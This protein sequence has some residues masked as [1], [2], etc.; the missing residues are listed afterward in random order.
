MNGRPVMPPG[1]VN[2]QAVYWLTLLT[3][4]EADDEQRRAFE[5][6]LAE[7]KAHQT[8]WER[9]HRLWREIEGLAEQDFPATAP[10]PVRKAPPRRAGFSYALACAASLVLA[11]FL[12]RNDLAYLFA[13]YR[14]G[15]GDTHSPLTLPD[16]SEVQLN[17][18]TALSVDY[19]T[20]TR[21]L[22]LHG[23]E[24]WFKVAP[25]PA[26][27][28]EVVTGYGSVRA[29]GTAF[30]I[31]TLPDSVAVTV[32]EH[33]VRITLAN[34]EGVERLPE[35]AAIRFGQ[36]VIDIAPQADLDAASAWRQQRMIFRNKPLQ[37]VVEE[38]N[39]YRKGRI[40]LTSH[41]LNALPLTG[42]FDTTDP[43]EALQMIKASLDLSEYRL[44]DRLVFLYRNQK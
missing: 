4:G 1:D 30:D 40:V 12:W 6:W 25:N 13:D 3:S 27:P 22:V 34:G 35:G 42:T 18:G 8:A 33:A 17:S 31:K 10:L 19:S 32:L 39:R 21:K 29:L 23:G 36:K 41:S 37:D 15:I 11:V 38:L 28:F 20:S 7:N 44:T 5:H 2:E 24:A 9:A 26:R 14:T 43:E 16:G